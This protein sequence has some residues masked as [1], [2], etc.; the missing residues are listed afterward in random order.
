MNKTLLVSFCLLVSAA[1]KGQESIIKFVGD[2][3][4]VDPF[5][6]KFST[7]MRVLSK[8]K[9]LLNKRQTVDEHGNP[10]ISGLYKVFNPFSLN[11]NEVEMRFKSIGNR[12]YFG[13][14]TPM[15]VY[16]L[17]A[18]FPGGPES[19]K[20][21]R[22]DYWQMVNRFRRLYTESFFGNPA[23]KPLQKKD[24]NDY[25]DNRNFYFAGYRDLASSLLN[26]TILPTSDEIE[27]NIGVCLAVLNDRVYPLGHYPGRIRDEYYDLVTWKPNLRH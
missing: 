16:E 17:T 15:Y 20:K 19:I 21:I 18:R 5:E 27:I 6:A 7:F 22:K 4:R 14:A 11:A 8:D 13:V 2:Y 24:M 1:S 12:T 10:S 26:W 23:Q 25:G 3:F 9:E